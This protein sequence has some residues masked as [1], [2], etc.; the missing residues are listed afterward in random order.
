LTKL[1]SIFFFFLLFAKTPHTYGQASTMPD[2]S[3]TISISTQKKP[4][5]TLLNDS[6]MYTQLKKRMYKTK[7]GK[8]LYGFF[9][10]DVY[11][12]A[13]KGQV[14]SIEVNPFEQY[15]GQIIR[16]IA[17]KR[18]NVFGYSVYDTTRR[19][20]NLIEK[21]GNKLHNSTREAVIRNSF[22][23][24]RIGDAVDAEKFAN[25]ERLLR[26]QTFLHDARIYLE[27]APGKQHQVDVL[28]V[29]QD[30]WALEPIIN[31]SSRNKYGLELFHNNFLGNA[32]Q[33][34]LSYNYDKLSPLQKKNFYGSYTIPYIG[35]SLVSA[36]GNMFYTGLEKSANVRIYRPF[37]T[38]L[39]KYAGAAELGYFRNQ[40]QNK[41]RGVD[42]SYYYPVH[43]FLSDLWLGRAFPLFFGTEAFKKQSRIVLAARGRKYTYT[44]R[45]QLSADSNQTYQNRRTALFSLGFSNRTY[46]R[47]LL[48]Y[49]FGRTEDVPQGYLGSVIYGIENAELGRRNY[50]G[51]KLAKGRYL[52]QDRG[53]LYSLINIGTYIKAGKAEQGILSYEGYYYTPLI[54]LKTSKIRQFVNFNFTKG[55][56]RFNTIE[57]R[58]N[59]S[60][61]GIRG[62]RSDSLQGVEKLVFNFETVLFSRASVMGFRMAPYIFA[63]LGWVSYQPQ[64]MLHNAPYTGFGL[65]F[66]FRNENLTFSTF[67]VR[68]GIYPNIPNV[69][70]FR[71][72]FGGEQSLRLKDFDISA[73]AEIV[74]R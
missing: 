64:A 45:P 39:V 68:M 52:K 54:S 5:K 21:L 19:A 6:L 37:L 71:F 38:P 31:Y 59:L 50:Y 63:D 26:Q 47:D 42:S 41:I 56:N 33:V 9:F 40:L 69:S 17:V 29:T 49:G 7:I 32:N 62:V 2:S 57:E 66:R 3:Q 36:Q 48:V 67:Q 34:R 23:T 18:L 51:V 24:F 60:N 22:L 58:L 65:G 1:Y 61:D 25:N 74:F 72:A 46:R 16:S 15:E 70:T 27:P 20:R 53:Y 43:H 55:L 28:V 35:R 11:N 8:G 30:T 14:S 4:G 44:E 13:A 73:P 12:S 10:K